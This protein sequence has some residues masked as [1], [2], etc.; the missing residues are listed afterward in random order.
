MLETSRLRN[1]GEIIKILKHSTLF[2]LLIFVSDNEKVWLTKGKS[3]L[4]KMFK[5]FMMFPWS[6][7]CLCQ[8][9]LK[10]EAQLDIL[11]I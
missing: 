3:L 7:G 6:L 10:T 2:C 1:V 4:T 5:D 11:I 9:L 8:I